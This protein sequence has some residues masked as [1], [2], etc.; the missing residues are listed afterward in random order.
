MIINGKKT[1]DD[2][3]KIFN[4]HGQKV[5]EVVDKYKYLGMWINA[6]NS[7]K[8]HIENLAKSGKRSTYMTTKALREFGQING[9]FLCE[10][11]ETLTLSRMK[12]GG[13]LCFQDNLNNLNQIQY[14]FYKRFCYLKTTTPNYCLIGEFGIKPMEF[15]FYK[16]ALNYWLRLL[17]ADEKN[18]TKTLYNQIQGNITEK[19]YAKTWSTQIK[20]LL[21]DL[22]LE[23]IWE[24]QAY[25]DK[26]NYR[27]YKNIIVMRLTEHFRDM[28]IQSA[29]HSNKGI[30][31]LELAKFSCE[32]KKYLNFI[33]ND[34]SVI[35][36][37]KLRTGN[38]SLLVE[39]KRYGDRKEY[40]ER[41]CNLCKLGKVQDLYHVLQEC[42]H[43]KELRGK[44]I[45]FLRNINKYELYTQ[46]ENLSRNQIK[47]ITAFM[48]IAENTVKLK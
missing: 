3:M 46:L 24:R 40:H 10:S 47:G 23:E 25:I 45:Q 11:F 34:K 26:S 39:T 19:S 30:D 17:T 9:N 42:P 33:M 41:I 20:K 16:A 2:H 7:N 43:F 5:I 12:Y 18:L 27:K 44:H 28:W 15:H 8:C 32:R 21:I 36:M 13:E 22:K 4:E 14:Q 1:V 6:N 37:L 31:Y 29:K 48:Q 38:H 35:H